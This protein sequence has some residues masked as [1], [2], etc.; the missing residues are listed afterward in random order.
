[1]HLAIPRASQRPHSDRR[2]AG[3]TA[4]VAAKVMGPLKDFLGIVYMYTKVNTKDPA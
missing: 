4:T 2:P 1:M 3:G